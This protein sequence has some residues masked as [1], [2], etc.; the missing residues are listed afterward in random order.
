M[1][2]QRTPKLKE[3]SAK[4]I[5]G[6]VEAELKR[7]RERN[8]WLEAENEYLKKL[9]ALIRAEEELNGKKPK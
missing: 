7:L 4:P 2:K 5:D 8:L 1:S 6:D 3:P 9:D